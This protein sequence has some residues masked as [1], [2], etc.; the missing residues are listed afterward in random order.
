MN[1]LFIFGFGYVSQFLADTLKKENWEIAGTTRDSIKA[2]TLERWGY[3][4]Y[5]PK[6]ILESP[7]ILDTYSHILYSIPPL[8]DE[9]Y[10]PLLKDLNLKWLGYLSATSVYGDHQGN[11]VDET[12]PLTP[13]STEG[14]N[15][16]FVEEKFLSLG[17]PSHIFRLT[18]IYGP[19]RNALA[20]V[21]AGKAQRID[22]PGHFLSR[23]HVD[24]ICQALILSMKNPMP[25]QIFNLTDSYPCPSREVIEYACSLLKQEF[26]P[27]IPYGDNISANLKRFY[28]ENRRV[29]NKKI[30][31]V[32]NFNLKY[33]T[34][35]EGLDSLMN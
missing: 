12:T 15:R 23:V 33:P 11:W 34:Y 22:K 29:E 10:I 18:G 4:I 7:N 20:S 24:D 35:K 14:K 27:L 16:L 17:G 28:M 30:L 1:K 26:P 6:M 9:V 31:E 19:Y 25:Q 13:L 2:A 8:E 32:L 5:S 3:K 21:M